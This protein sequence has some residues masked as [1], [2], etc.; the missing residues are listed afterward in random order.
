MSEFYLPAAA[1]AIKQFPFSRFQNHRKGYI[2]HLSPVIEPRH[3]YA[4]H[5]LKTYL[6]LVWL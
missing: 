6:R 4:N 3:H 2:F 5:A 1:D